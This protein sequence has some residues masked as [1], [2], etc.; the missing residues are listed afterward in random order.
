MM[1]SKKLR[2]IPQP[3]SSISGLLFLC[4]SVIWTF[5]SCNNDNDFMNQI[6]NGD[7]DLLAFNRID[8]GS[9]TIYVIDLDGAWKFKS[10]DEDT[11][12]EGIVPG[13]VQQDMIRLERLENPFYRDKELD[14]QWVEKK[15]WEYERRFTVDEAFLSMD[16]VILDCR[17]LDVICELYLN[18]A[19]VATTQNMFIEYEFD[20]KQQLRIGTNT[21]RA[22][23]RSVLQW[24]RMQAEADPRITWSTGELS[25]GDAL[26]GL[27][28]YSR[29]AASDLSLKARVSFK[30]ITVA[31]KNLRIENGIAGG[32]LRISDPELWWPDGWGEHPLYTVNAEL[33]DADRMVHSKKLK[34]GL[35]TITFSQEKDE[36]G[37]K[38][39]KKG[40]GGMIF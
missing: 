4:M 31:E 16:K 27:L 23:F 34:I 30:G 7:A 11:W 19:L 6:K 24:N 20:V 14:A 5:S 15:E 38:F 32:Q 28:F 3:G 25:T 1:K 8:G 40:N 12:M 35:R 37:E 9:D 36:R 33:F 26:K 21:L 2:I 29:K 13:T 22:V 39:G 10:T 17:G 18:D